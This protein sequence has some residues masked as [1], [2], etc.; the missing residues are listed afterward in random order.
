MDTLH[1]G[2][3]AD[4]DND[5][6]NNVVPVTTPFFCLLSFLP[7]LPLGKYSLFLYQNKK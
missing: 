5:D 7:S 3:D 2:D 6:N 1:E 4:N